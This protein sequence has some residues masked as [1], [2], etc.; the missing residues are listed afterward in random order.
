[1]CI[2]GVFRATFSAQRF[3]GVM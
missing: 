3:S 2:V 1:M